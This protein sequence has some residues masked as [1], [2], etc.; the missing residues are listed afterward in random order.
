MFVATKLCLSRQNICRSKHVFVATKVLSRQTYYCRD[1]RRVLSRETR[2][3][4]DKRMLVAIKLC[5]D[6]ILFVAADICRDKILSR[7]TRFCCDKGVVSTCIL[8]SRFFLL[9]FLTRKLGLSK[10]N[11]N[12]IH[13]R[14]KMI[15]RSII[16][17]HVIYL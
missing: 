15:N 10:N 2:V 3:C 7:R 14:W 5:R 13:F 17:L 16:I 8:F 4:H 11:N 1:K 9:I 6:K 12:Y